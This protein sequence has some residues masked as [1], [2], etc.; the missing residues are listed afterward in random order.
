[1]APSVP[2]RRLAGEHEAA[3]EELLEHDRVLNL[4]L[5]GMLGSVPLDRLHWYGV[6]DGDRLRAAVLVL[7]GRLCVPYAPEPQDAVAIARHLDRHERPCTS[8]GP[9]AA[10]DAIWEAWG[11]RSR[12]AQVHAQR[13]YALR[14]P[15]P[16]GPDLR[17]RRARHEDWPVVSRNAI[18]ME[19]EDLGRDPSADD[20]RRHERVVQDR[21]AAGRTWVVE[22]EGD[23]VYQINAGTALPWGCQVGGT[24]VPHAHRGQGWAQL[25]TAEVCA[26]LMKVH[27]LVTLHV[28]E[29]NAPA[30][31]VYENV[32]FQRATPLRLVTV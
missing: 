4:F 23:I 27:P 1:M 19:L 20:P 3:L 31:R 8:I 5:L 25:G 30:V 18:L 11:Q 21:I 28:R 22:H 9:R 16:H 14:T 7:P 6:P 32:G 10:V 15:P 17:V 13:L 29:D 26:R 12:P 24:Y 2:V